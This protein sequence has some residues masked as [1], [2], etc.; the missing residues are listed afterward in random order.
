MLLGSCLTLVAPFRQ[1]CSNQEHPTQAL[2]GVLGQPPLAGARR[3]RQ[4]GTNVRLL[5]RHCGGVRAGALKSENAILRAPTGIP[6][7]H[8]LF[9]HGPPASND[10]PRSSTKAAK[11][12]M[13]RAMTRYC[14]LR[15]GYPRSVGLPALR[16]A[17]WASLAGVVVG[18]WNREPR[19]GPRPS[20]LFP[21]GTDSCGCGR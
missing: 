11:S 16:P 4:H 13:L 19:N 17:I 12:M 9:I 3:G 5:V 10:G 18:H 15:S 2:V 7:I 21:R 14:R 6:S 8:P 1:C 20:P